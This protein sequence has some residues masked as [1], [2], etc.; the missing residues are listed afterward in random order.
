[1]VSPQVLYIVDMDQS[2]SCVVLIYVHKAMVIHRDMYNEVVLF[3]R[4]LAAW[5][6]SFHI[7]MSMVLVTCVNMVDISFSHDTNAYTYVH[8][9]IHSHNN[10]YIDECHDFSFHDLD[11]K[12]FHICVYYN[13]DNHHKHSGNE[14]PQLIHMAQSLFSFHN[15]ISFQSSGHMYM[16]QS[17][18]SSDT[19]VHISFFFHKYDDIPQTVD[20]NLFDY[21]LFFHK[22]K[23]W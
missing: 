5:S 6:L 16:H 8:N 7:Y 2:D 17:D 22:H 3:H 10:L 13:W 1:M 18:I 19:N 20:H 15:N 23:F 9:P 21:K 12:F 4:E 14:S 11:N